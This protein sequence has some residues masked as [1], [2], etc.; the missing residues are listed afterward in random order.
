MANILVVGLAHGVQTTSGGCSSSQKEEYTNFITQ[1]I[2]QHGID[3]VAE[4]WEPSNPNKTIA[5]ELVKPPVSWEPIDLPADEKNALGVPNRASISYGE[6]AQA[7]GDSTQIIDGGFQTHIS[8]DFVRVE[9]RAQQ[10]DAR[11]QHMIDRVIEH[12]DTH[13]NILVLCGFNHLTQ[14]AK[15]FR[16]AGHS[17]KEC[18]SL[19]E[20]LYGKKNIRVKYPL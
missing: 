4:E 17:V 18:D 7:D 8:S 15:K 1:I 2:G 5:Q 20:V 14:L 9:W 3:L 13:K 6:P 12:C 19:I 11:D 16:E 10:D